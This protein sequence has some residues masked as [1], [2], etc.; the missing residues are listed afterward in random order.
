M[1]VSLP[2][3]KLSTLKKQARDMLSQECTSTR[4]ISQI[5]GSMVAAHP[6][7]LPAPLHYRQLERAKLQ[8]MKKGFA[9]G[10]QV[11]MLPRMKTDLQWWTT[12]PTSFNGRPLQIPCWDVAIEA[13]A[14]NL[15]WGASC[16]GSTTG[17][18]WTSEEQSHHIN[19]FRV[20][21]SLLGLEI[22]LCQP[23]SQRSI[24]VLLHLDNIIAITIL[25]KMGGSHSAV[26]SDLASQVWDWCIE[27]DIL[28]MQNTSQEWRI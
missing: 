16:Q 1:S 28:I 25:N 22:F 15:G 18:P 7:I 17:G 23:A 9:L 5:L 12:M 19:F 11:P 21:G 20:E 6:A 3:Q 10:W 2:C 4:E 24:S 8:Y 27:R 26:L 13:D 14:S